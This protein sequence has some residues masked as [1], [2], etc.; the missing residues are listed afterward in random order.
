MYKRNLV[1]AAACIG[2]LLFGIVFL[3]LGTVSTFLQDKFNLDALTAASLASSLPFG[4]LLGSVVFGPVVDRFGYKILLIVCGVVIMA[5]LEAI[6]FADSLFILQLSFFFIGF[7]GGAINGGTN[8][9]ASDIFS[10]EKG[11]KLS[12]LGVFFGI[13]ALG[14]PVVIGSLSA[15]YS[16][17]TIISA[18]GLFVL[19]PVIYFIV[20][21]FPQPKITQGFPLK[22]SLG[23]VKETTLI[24]MGLV[25]FF[26]SGLEGMIGNWTTSYLK[27]V[28]MTTENALYALS[29]QVA[30]L[31]VTRLI[32]SQL[33]K[34]VRSEIVLY[35]SYAILFA[36]AA[37]LLSATSFE[38]AALAMILFGIGTAANF[39]VILG[40]V[41]EMYAHLSGTAFSVVIV[42]ALIGN[43][44]L[45]FLV[46]TLSG[47]FGIRQFPVLL[48]ISVVLM[49]LVLYIVL[50]KRKAAAKV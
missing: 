23:L 4:M 26:E 13:G 39:P 10:D 19:L 40:Y 45:N 41:G 3:S 15:V 47:S 18:I 49:T 6:A 42:L 22:E 25:L 33:L 5:A 2:M 28:N 1:F 14:M 50:G 27:E 37:V 36:G 32:L 34:K 9:L 17:E 12:L 29:L 35:V 30:A 16:Y 38:Q 48:M 24:L 31:S 20:V 44:I 46:G 11:A 8:A 7:G 21:K 43:T